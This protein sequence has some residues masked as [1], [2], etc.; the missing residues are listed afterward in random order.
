[1]YGR[2][3]LRP[4]RVS[5]RARQRALER[6][7][8]QLAQRG[9]T[10][11]YA[12]YQAIVLRPAARIY[13]AIYN[14]VGSPTSHR[15]VLRLVML[16][17]L[18]VACVGMAI[19]AYA[20]FYHTWVPVA[21]TQK[22]V[23][24][25]YGSAYEPTPP[26]ASVLLD[27]GRADLPV[28]QTDPI[29]PLFHENFEYDVA[30]E[31]RVLMPHNTQN[32]MYIFSYSDAMVR[33][34]LVSGETPI[35]HASRP[36]LLVAEPRI[37]RWLARIARVVYRPFQREPIVPTQKIRVPL[38]RRVT[39]WIKGRTRSI[40]ATRANLMIDT[41]DFQVQSAV[42]RFDA[43]IS[44][45][46]Y[47]M[48]HHPILSFGLFVLLFA[49]IEFVV[50]GGLWTLLAVYFSYSRSMASSESLTE[51]LASAARLASQRDDPKH[52]LALLADVARMADA[53][54]VISENERVRE[55][56]THSLRVFFLPS[57]QAQIEDTIPCSSAQNEADRM[58]LRKKQVDACIG[59]SRLFFTTA[60]RHEAIPAAVGIML[61]QHVQGRSQLAPAEQRHLKIQLMRLEKQLETYLNDFRT[62]YRAQ[63]SLKHPAAQRLPEISDVF[64]DL[65]VVPHIDDDQEEQEE[66]HLEES[67]AQAAL[68]SYEARAPQSLR[69]YL[70]MLLVLHAVR[71]ANTMNAAQQELELL[72]NAPPPD[73]NR[74]SAPKDAD[75]TWRLD[76]RWF[77]GSKGGPL[78]GDG[79]KP[80]RPFVITG[81]DSN[82]DAR[83]S[84][85]ANVFRPSHR[86]PTMSIDEYLA[87]EQ[88][89][90]NVIR[91]GGP[92]Q[93]AAA[94]PREQQKE[95]SQMDG[96]LEADQAEEA[97][98][99]E[100]IHWD[101]YTEMFKRGAGNTMNRG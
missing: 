64:Y 20:G 4:T 9:E 52:A 90:G 83:S 54:A 55:I 56:S 37:I 42:L 32:S 51:R 8:L 81:S 3:R 73:M 96:T 26:Y 95:T 60:S 89:R 77:S 59:A 21:T 28:W 41:S 47:A 53:L 58:Q 6:R 68:Q 18:H 85:K 31:M 46:I 66:N 2:R 19:L 88:R 36:M 62:Q 71:T 17:A 12:V 74:D 16:T 87:E 82:I 70:L 14:L 29:Q 1:M 40:M 48:Y 69:D 91:D 27:G 94:T 97:A 49:T 33:L 43:H 79:G 7:Q 78:L 24:L 15:I 75:D 10:I 45:F 13:G 39:P 30:L 35:Y 38:L 93:Q 99:Q 5:S 84:T 101:N 92:A 100:A 50:A 34:D 44:G 63:A 11:V 25:Q 98:R 61:K 80:L 57:L 65:L 86:L 23:Y 72:Q 67:S 76:S 22:D